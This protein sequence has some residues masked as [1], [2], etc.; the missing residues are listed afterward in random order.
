M[1]SKKNSIN[2]KFI[3]I[4]I[5]AALITCLFTGCSNS[6]SK[7][8]SSYV[9]SLIA[10]NYIGA[11]DEYKK[12]T[13]ADSTDIDAMY[14][15]NVTRLANNLADFYDLNIS[16]DKELAPKMVDIAKK[17]YSRTKYETSPARTD[18]NIYYV[19]ITIYPIDILNQVNSEVS[20]YIDNF[21]SHVA[22]GDYNNYKK[23][24]YEHE[25]ASGIMDILDKGADNIT[26]R[27]PEKVTVRIIE[28]KS[29][30]YIG[31]EDFEAIDSA[32]IPSSAVADASAT[33]ASATDSSATVH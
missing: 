26:Y 22:N 16:S 20:S 25:Y 11:E 5:A 4:F 27:T 23:E 2:I 30:Y 28:T 29:S 24:D 1:K 3:S 33:D 18:N 21:N 8:Y 12:M 6:K 15:E 32:I 31:N 17:I 19:D 10:A 7:L 14:L 9:N 13:G